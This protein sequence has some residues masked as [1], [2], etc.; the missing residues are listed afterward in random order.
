MILWRA[1]LRLRGPKI[2]RPP[3]TSSQETGVPA[4]IETGEKEAL[5]RGVNSSAGKCALNRIMLIFARRLIYL[6]TICC[7]R[8]ETNME[9]KSVKARHVV[10][11]TKC[12]YRWDCSVP[13]STPLVG[14]PACQHR[15][16]NVA[17]EAAEQ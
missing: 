8:D 16:P 1:P 7:S 10:I 3:Y 2:Y 17:E 4:G 12:G 6:A 15:T 9:T 5:C 13:A 14:C 11:C